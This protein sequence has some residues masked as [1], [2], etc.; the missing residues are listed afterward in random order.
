MEIAAQDLLN[1]IYLIYDALRSG[2]RILLEMTIIRASPTLA[3]K[4][5]DALSLLVTIT[6]LWL[7]LEFSTNLKNVIRA[8]VILG[9]ILLIISIAIS[10]LY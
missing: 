4:Y 8:V 7:L 3:Q 10:V 2:I 6:A 1:F 5:A 9:W